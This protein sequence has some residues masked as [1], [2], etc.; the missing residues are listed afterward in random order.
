MTAENRAIRDR[1]ATWAFIAPVSNVIVTED[2]GWEVQIDRVTLV[3]ASHLPRRRKRLGIRDRISKLRSQ[4]H[5]VFDRFF[6]NVN[7]FAILR[8]TGTGVSAE[9]ECLRLVQEELA[10]LS[11]SQLCYARRNRSAKPTIQ[12]G[13]MA[14]MLS[15]LQLD[16]ETEMWRQPN[17]AIPPFMSLRLDGS[18]KE[19]QRNSFF[20]KLLIVIR[21][22]EYRQK[23]WAQ[24]LRRVAI[25]VGNSQSHSEVY[26][27]LIWN[28]I[29]LELLVTNQ[30][31]MVK[32][33]IDDRPRAILGGSPRWESER[34]ANRIIDLYRKRNIFVHEGRIDH[35]ESDDL[36]FSDRLLCNLLNNIV[37]FPGI[38][39]SKQGLVDF[40]EDV[41]AAERLGQR[42]VIR[43][44]A[45][46]IR[47]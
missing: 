40:A 28:M 11:S 23:S 39:P 46:T 14:D 6:S 12:I 1:Q 2:I 41:K 27:S 3:A 32:N 37:R 8:Q 16:T 31:E 4:K 22:D 42:R 9:T 19:Q 13:Q 17:N 10:I 7:T 21:G 18:W 47:R 43:P 15:Y 38:F 34:F 5:G 30:G 35:I 20:D 24:I 45:M 29:A 25:L 26:L 36:V 33:E 44:A